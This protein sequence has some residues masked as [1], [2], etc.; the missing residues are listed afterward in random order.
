MAR[1]VQERH[2]HLSP[3]QFEEE[4]RSFLEVLGRGLPGLEVTHQEKHAVADGE[5][6]IDVTIRF[7]ALGIRFVGLVECKYWQ[8]AVKREHIM[9]LKAKLDSIGAAKGVMVTNTGYQKGAREYARAHGIALVKFIDNRWNVIEAHIQAAPEIDI[10]SPAEPRV[11][12]LW[13]LE[14][15][16]GTEFNLI[17][18]DD[19]R[20]EELMEPVR[21]LG[22]F[23]RG[24]AGA[25]LTEGQSTPS[26]SRTETE[27]LAK[28]KQS[29][30]VDLQTRYD[31]LI[32][33]RRGA[34]LTE[35]EH[36]EVLRLTEQ[37]EGL[38][39]ERLEYLAEL[40]RLRGTTLRDLMKDL[41]I[42]Q[43]PYV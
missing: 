35:S 41:G 34:S 27:L 26:L 20:I 5:Y 7:E 40:S 16:T 23:L 28:I 33:K 3:R 14:T 15:E 39:A 6:T 29:V 30:P 37:V 31:E 24:V 25:T 36:D 43:P 2:L 19:L 22:R 4:V 10:E 11:A 42:K 13:L 1:T 17:M 12:A 21:R 18:N 38:D 9:V 8:R 32:T